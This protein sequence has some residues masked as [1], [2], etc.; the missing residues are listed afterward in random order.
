MMVFMLVGFAAV[1]ALAAP[2]RM[3]TAGWAYRSPRLA[4]FA[5]HATTYAVVVALT[6]AAA[7]ALLHWDRGHDLAC[8]AWQVCL[9]A[10]AGVHGRPSQILAVGGLAALMTVGV[11]LARAWGQV[12]G[13]AAGERR[14][15]VALL[16]LTGTPR[17]D[18]DATVLPDLEPAAYL[19]PGRY[20]HVVITAGTLGRLND[21]EL[22]AVLAHE[23]AHAAGHHHRL[24]AA[25][26][27]LHRA[28]PGVSI[29]TQATRQVDRLV[30]L[31]ADEAAVRQHGALPLARALVAMATP[32]PGVLSAAGGDAPERLRRLLEPP[33][34]LAWPVQAIA[35]V[36]WTLLP[37]VP[38]L[39]VAAVR[40]PPIPG[41]TW[42]S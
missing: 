14:R 22:A 36:G 37:A 13:A 42:L 16:R 25:M 11:R 10:L 9:D 35:A 20:P 3:V 6:V 26:R 19:V 33:P 1:L 15:H 18:L 31:C 30:E 27:L 34:R 8:A 21:V 32:T 29:F 39:I 38:L 12:I 40:F 41:L 24:C 2:G 28:F 4:I 17:P 5:W 7:V 23:R